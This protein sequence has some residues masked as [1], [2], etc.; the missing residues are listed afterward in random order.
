MSGL[1][2]HADL[3]PSDVAAGLVLLHANH[4]SFKKS[5]LANA[6]TI[7]VPAH[8]TPHLNMST[9]FG[10]I[11]YVKLLQVLIFKSVVSSLMA[12][13]RG[14]IFSLLQKCS[15]MISWRRIRAQRRGWL[16]SSQLITSNTPGVHTVGS[17]F[18]TWAVGPGCGRWKVSW[19]ASVVAGQSQYLILSF[20]SIP[21]RP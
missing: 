17:T 14:C 13:I 12:S 5:S 18:S 9:N 10:E 16:S 6:G 4:R 3:V 11:F 15:P 7:A 8:L 2:T 20:F 1:F 19:S 21:S